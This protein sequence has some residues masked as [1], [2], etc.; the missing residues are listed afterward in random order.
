MR[1]LQVV[2]SA[3]GLGRGSGRREQKSPE[4]SPIPKFRTH[5][6]D[7]YGGHGVQV[8]DGVPTVTL[9][10]WLRSPAT[11]TCTQVHPG[12]TARY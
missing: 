12:A 6:D 9:T 10:V 8:G 11:V 3:R 1:Y 4:S 7:A 2:N 5:S